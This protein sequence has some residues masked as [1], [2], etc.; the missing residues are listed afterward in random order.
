MLNQ[1]QMSIWCYTC[2][3]DLSQIQVLVGKEK[4]KEELED[5]IDKVTSMFMQA[6]QKGH[7][8][9]PIGEDSDS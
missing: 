1:K 2:D 3:D 7:T 6:H 9:C 8:A 5:F 4:E